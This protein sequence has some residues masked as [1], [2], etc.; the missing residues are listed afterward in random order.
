VQNL[1]RLA[2]LG[3]LNDYGYYEAMDFSRQ[4]SHEG[5]RGLIVQATWR[6]TKA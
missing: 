5:E 6:T 4:P 2:G 3:L 1:K